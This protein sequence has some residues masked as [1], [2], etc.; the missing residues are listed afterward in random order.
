MS[1]PLSPE[2]LARLPFFPLPG[3]VFFPHTLLP[4]HLFEPRYRQMVRYCIDHRQP[5][6]VVRIQPGFEDQ[7]PF[8]PPVVEV[9]GVGELVRHQRT[10]DGRYN[11][12]LRGLARVRLLREIETE[13]PFRFAQA[14]PYA[15][16]MALDPVGR[17]GQ[18]ATLRALGT[19]LGQRWPSAASALGEVLR[20]A[21]SPAD[22]IDALA[23][24]IF[25]E[26]DMRQSVLESRSAADRADRVEA[27]LVELL[28]AAPVEGPGI[29]A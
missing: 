3:L 13:H 15:D 16:G 17:A 6:A 26:P 28:A 2:H 7:Q 20:D 1:T 9:C 23:G 12:V 27:R 4:L 29:E 21:R 10:N 14:E 5:L 18:A 11:I 8:D 19:S 22:L 25:S 24:M